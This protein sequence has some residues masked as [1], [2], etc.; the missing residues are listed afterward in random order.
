MQKACQYC[1]RENKAE[2]L[3][4]PTAWTCLPCLLRRCFPYFTRLHLRLLTRFYVSFAALVF[5]I[6]LPGSISGHGEPFSTRM[7]GVILAFAGPFTGMA[8]R[9]FDSAYGL[10]SIVPYCCV[11]FGGGLLFQLIPLP[12]GSM[13]VRIST[14]CVGLLGWFA[15]TVLSTLVANS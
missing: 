1:G 2:P 5:L 3:R 14:W 12:R 11:L 4:D 8:S 15:G 6:L 10:P 7:W 13:R 9:G